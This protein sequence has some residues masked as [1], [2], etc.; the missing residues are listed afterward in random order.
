VCTF[1]EALKIYSYAFLFSVIT[2]VV[3]VTMFPVLTIDNLLHIVTISITFSC[4]Y[5][6]SVF[7]LLS[8]FTSEGCASADLLLV[9]VVVSDFYESLIKSVLY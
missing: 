8:H 4:G 1:P 7:A 2:T 5:N 6:I 9:T 3:V